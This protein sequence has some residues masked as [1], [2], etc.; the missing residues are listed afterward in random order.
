MSTSATPSIGTYDYII[1][2][3]GSA[4][5]VLANRLTADGRHKVL[6]L[7]AGGRDSNP[8]IHIPIGYSRLFKDQNVNWMYETEPQPEF[9]GRRVFQPR[10]KV[11]GGSSSINGLV[12]I[13]GQKQDYDLWRQL[14]NPGWAYDDVLPYFRRSEDQQHGADDWHGAG[15]PIAVSD[16][17]ETHPLCD[18]FIA[19]GVQSGWPRNDDFNGSAQEGIGYF[20][21]TSRNG[22]RCSTASGYLKP[23]R[24]RPNLRVETHAHA[25][26]ILFEGRTA[27][28]VEFTQH[29]RL[30]R[31][32]AAGE[33]ILSGGAI[34]SPQLL[35]LSGIGGADV[36]RA[37]G[38]PVV[39]D[40][41]MVGE[42]L[43]DH[44]QVRIVLRSK[45]RVTWNDQTA[46]L[47]GRAKLALRYALFRKG[48][49]AVSAGYAGAFFKTREELEVPDI[50]VHFL[51]FSTDRMGEK[52]HSFPGFSA[53]VCQLRPES[54]GTI[55]IESADPFRPPSIRPNYFSAPADREVNVA[56]LKK[57]RAML[58]AEALESYVE[59]EVHPGP[60]VTGD[61]ALLDYCRKA[62][63]T[64]YHPAS[65]CAMGPEPDA[66]VAPDLK[67]NGVDRLRVVDASVMPRLISGNTNA[68]VIMIAE[69]AADMIL[70]A[71]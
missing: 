54:R 51:L 63:T 71:H 49:I 64:I 12:Y 32:D 9:G 69:K 29:G 52:L 26:R 7:E 21:T 3:A 25:T 53:S 28:G 59:A 4:G 14:G 67:V 42:N 16:Q 57:L 18:A 40:A 39:H 50:Q 60:D 47:A 55:H 36:L 20:Q 10:G 37:H 23:A 11:L 41:P 1:V 58:Q 70:E 5:C 17:N 33:V 27:T 35:E 30:R 62:A 8:W 2:G 6:L 46:S 66:V 13:R 68:P 56:G 15:G 65:T 34:N 38:I 45:Q 31:A 24:R 48:P 43:Q 44:L 61:A 19:A 22:F